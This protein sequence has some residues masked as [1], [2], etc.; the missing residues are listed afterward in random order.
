MPSSAR[1][2]TTMCVMQRVDLG[3]DPYGFGLTCILRQPL[4]QLLLIVPERRGDGTVRFDFFRRF[5]QK[6]GELFREGEPVSA[7]MPLHMGEDVLCL[8][9]GLNSDGFA[10][11]GADGVQSLVSLSSGLGVYEIVPGF[12]A[13]LL[14]AVLASLQTEKPG[15]EVDAI[16]DKAVAK[17]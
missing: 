10:A 17:A 16:F 13:G 5:P 3:I 1:C 4:L 6:T 14:A 11:E 8:A 9:A 2:F 15:P 12:A 7:H